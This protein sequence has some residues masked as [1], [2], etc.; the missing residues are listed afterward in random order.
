MN[1][2]KISD[3]KLG[4]IFMYLTGK[5]NFIDHVKDAE[6]VAVYLKESFEMEAIRNHKKEWIYYSDVYNGDLYFKVNVPNNQWI[7]MFLLR[8]P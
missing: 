8:W 2:Y 3:H 1:S 7:T 5:R 6:L 4:R